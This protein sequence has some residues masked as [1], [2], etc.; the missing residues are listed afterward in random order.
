MGQLEV[1]AGP[2]WATTGMYF[3]K[4]V[5][6][7][8]RPTLPVHHLLIAVTEIKTDIAAGNNTAKKQQA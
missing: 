3:L 6:R 7:Q 8:A 4:G 5:R 2:G 1:G